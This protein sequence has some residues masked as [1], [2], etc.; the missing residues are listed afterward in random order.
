MYLGK[1]LV[2][3]YCQCISNCFEN[4]YKIAGLSKSFC[5]FIVLYIKLNCFLLMTN[6][7]NA[8]KIKIIL[9]SP[10]LPHTHIKMAAIIIKTAKKKMP[11]QSK[12]TNI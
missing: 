12:E 1:I 9:Q 7:M 4:T 2:C 3:L 10:I 6:I 8:M 5:Q 11:V